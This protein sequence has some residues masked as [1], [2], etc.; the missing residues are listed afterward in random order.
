MR[1]TVLLLTIAV[2]LLAGCVSNKA[3][4][5]EK[6][7]VN[8]LEARQNKQDTELEVIRKDIL[9]EKERMEAMIIRMNGTDEKLTVLEPMQAEIDATGGDIAY[10][11]DE[12]ST[13]KD[14]MADTINKHNSLEQRLVDQGAAIAGEI[15]GLRIAHTAELDSVKA[16]HTMELAEL[17]AGHD[18]GI[19]ELKAGHDAGMADLQTQISTNMDEIRLELDMLAEDTDF[20]LEAYTDNLAELRSVSSNF[21]TKDELSAVINE[22]EKVTAT[23]TGLTKEVQDLSQSNLGKAST[24]EADVQ[25]L[26]D[27][28]L[29]MYAEFT[30]AGMVGSEEMEAKLGVE[31]QKRAALMNDLLARLSEVESDI[32][33][34]ISS[35]MGVRDESLQGIS[36]RLDDIEMEIEV[37][38][39]ENSA[40]I[41]SLRED[42]ELQVTTLK[43]E[44]NDM[45]T[46]TKAEITTSNNTIKTDVSSLRQRVESLS[47]EV[48]GVST[49]LEDVIVQERAKKEKRR[50]LSIAAQYK[51]AL[52][53]YNKRKY[54]ESIVMFEDFLAQYPSESLSANAYYWIGENYYAGKKFSTALDSFIYVRDNF[55]THHKVPDAMLKVGM[56]YYNLDMKYQANDEFTKLKTS[57]PKYNRMDLVNKYLRLT[58]N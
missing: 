8:V 42:Q 1:R 29:D 12:V 23:L 2:L 32:K 54:E 49:D 57:Y 21:A 4:K 20:S 46:T 35:E 30:A 41:A 14:G 17:K 36:G 44:V 25:D 58:A 9:A 16:T 31:S 6:E 18:A 19:A 11:Q 26:R 40:W 7:K 45:L 47:T 39:E 37:M 15:E 3:F 43:T 24:L 38:R 51:A 56:C 13:L 27:M 10:L 55:P 48:K 53:A 5:V 50:Q 28:V 52:A 34:E 22:N 33:G